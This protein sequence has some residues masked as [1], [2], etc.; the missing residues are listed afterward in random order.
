MTSP[1]LA[2]KILAMLVE[3]NYKTFFLSRIANEL[4][5]TQIEAISIITEMQ[6]VTPNWITTKTAFEKETDI[7]L[8]YKRE[9]VIKKF[10][11]EGGYSKAQMNDKIRVEAEKREKESQQENWEANTAYVKQ[12]SKDSKNA[13]LIT[14]LSII[15]AV[16][17]LIVSIWLQ[18]C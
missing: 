1:E 11:I 10:I 16:A 13:L 2:D 3:A 17:A 7:R 12:A 18:K 15:V 6:S 5:M 4:N 14:R 8:D 9:T